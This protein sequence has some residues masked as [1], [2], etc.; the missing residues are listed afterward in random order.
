MAVPDAMFQTTIGLH[1]RRAR[2]HYYLA[3]GSHE[4]A[5]EDFEACGDL[6]RRWGSDLP[7]LVP[8]RTDLAAARLA[9]GL[10]AGTLAADQGRGWAPRTP[11]PGASRCECSPPPA[12]CAAG[13]RSCGRRSTCSRPPGTGWSWP[14]PWPR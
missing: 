9:G 8:W 12:S 11:A 6:M 13:R 10:S 14:R 7:G 5:M 4:A 3:C 2:G 1:Y